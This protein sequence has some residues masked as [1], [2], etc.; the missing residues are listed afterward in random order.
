MRISTLDALRG[1]AVALMVFV[2]CPGSWTHM[3]DLLR[4][5]KNSGIYIADMV[6]PMFLWSV[7]FSMYCQFEK[8]NGSPEV[9]SAIENSKKPYRKIWIRG[10]ILILLGMCLS[11]FGSCSLQNVR[12]PGILQRIGLIYL[13]FLL[14]LFFYPKWKYLVFVSLAIVF[15]SYLN[16]HLT[17]DFDWS[18][19]VLK[20][21]DTWF[22]WVDRTLLGSDHLWKQSKNYDPEGLLSTL[23]AFLTSLHGFFYAKYRKHSKSRLRWLGF[24]LAL[25]ILSSFLFPIRK[26]DW[27]L[28]YASLTAICISLLFLSLEKKSHWLGI[29]WFSILGRHALFSFVFLG[30]VGRIPSFAKGRTSVFSQI[31]S[32]LDPKLSSFVFSV[33]FLLI[34]WG[35]VFFWDRFRSELNPR[36]DLKT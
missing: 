4:H 13:A 30:L 23:P 8:T 3:Y 5:A 36:Q 9:S 32:F 12:I 15:L 16:L 18:L 28:S 11:F 19:E 14:L 2:N 25:A 6:F 1:I 26:D 10:F 35:I 22:A 27:T 33:L 21:E 31:S 29:T 24:T 20:Q 34:L 17:H 7:G